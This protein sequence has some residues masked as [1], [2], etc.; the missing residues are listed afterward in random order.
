MHAK[1]QQILKDLLLEQMEL[2]DSSQSDC[3]AN[4]VRIGSLSTEQVTGEELVQFLREAAALRLQ[5]AMKRSMMPATFYAWHDVQAGQLRF[6][7]INGPEESLPFGAPIRLVRDPEIVVREFLESGTRDGIPWSELRPDDGSPEP[8][9]Y[10]AKSP[11][12]VWAVCL[13]Q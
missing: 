7:T 3:E 10:T 8:P 4:L 11:L 12:L 9:Y 13:L 6:S 5:T 2:A 1:L